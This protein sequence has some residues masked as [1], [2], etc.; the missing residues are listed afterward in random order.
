[1]P[2]RGLRFRFSIRSGILM[3]IR[4]FGS[5]VLLV[6]AQALAGC[7]DRRSTPSPISPSGVTQPEPRL[8][9]V[10]ESLSGFGTTDLRDAD[11][12]IVQFTANGQLIWAADGTRLSGYYVTTV[13]GTHGV[14]TYIT[15]QI[16]DESCVFEVRFGTSGGERRAYLTVDYGH[17]NPGTLVDIAVVDGRLVMSPTDE[18]APGSYTLSG[19]VTELVNGRVVPVAGIEVHRGVT[20]GWQAA[21]TD[22]SGVYNLRG[23]YTSRDEVGVTAAGF[24]PFQEAVPI[25]GDTRFDIRLV[26]SQPIHP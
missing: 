2:V 14:V 23:M 16:C 8:V 17:D 24:E 13:P 5:V 19:A 25:S 1:M 10:T 22:D 6:F 9:T 18:F 21:R 20:G 26:R 3:A 15:G 12:Q 7:N 11:D 4:A